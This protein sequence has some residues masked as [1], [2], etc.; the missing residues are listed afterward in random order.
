M[1]QIFSRL[2]ILTHSKPHCVIEKEPLEQQQLP[3]ETSKIDSL[4]NANYAGTNPN[5]ARAIQAVLLH[6]ITAKLKLG[7]ELNRK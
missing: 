1:I 4:I 6:L 3:V 5:Y 2:K 7:A